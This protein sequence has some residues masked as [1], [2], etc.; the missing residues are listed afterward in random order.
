VDQALGVERDMDTGLG[1]ALVPFN[2][3]VQR[4]KLRSLCRKSGSG[5]EVM[6]KKEADRI[7]L[8]YLRA[9]KKHAYSPESHGNRAYNAASLK[10]REDD[11]WTNPYDHEDI[12]AGYLC[13][14]WA[15]LVH[16][17]LNH[18]ERTRTLKCWDRKAVAVFGEDDYEGRPV[19]SWVT[20]YLGDEWTYAHSAALDLWNKPGPWVYLQGEKGRAGKYRLD[21]EWTGRAER[22]RHL[23][24]KIYK[25]SRSYKLEHRPRKQG[26][27][28]WERPY[29]KPNP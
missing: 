29:H 28:E 21:T 24:D 7:W 15:M 16:Q 23:D 5:N 4:F 3:I 27:T 26:H 17:E 18:M 8:A 13:Y 2:D 14:Q 6:C 25:G 20:V 19:H 9:W 22:L 11:G 12:R 1:M 10:A